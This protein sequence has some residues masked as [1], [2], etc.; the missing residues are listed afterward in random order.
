MGYRST[1]EIM[2][3]P[4]AYKKVMDSIAEYNNKQTD[5]YPFKPDCDRINKEGVHII[6]FEYVIWC[7]SYEDVES[8]ENIL[9]ELNALE[10]E[11]LEGNRFKQILIGENNAIDE[12]SNDWDWDLGYDFSISVVINKPNGFKK[13]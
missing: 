13:L 7:G 4:K 9:S 3:E 11:N 8:V 5:G 12:Y 2:L 6:T 1:V 10:D